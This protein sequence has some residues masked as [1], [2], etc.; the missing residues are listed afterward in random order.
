MVPPYWAIG[1]REIEARVTSGRRIL[2]ACDFDGTLAPIVAQP[3]AARLPTATRLILQRLM[4]CPGVSLAFVSGRQLADLRDRVRLDGAMY[5]GNH[6]LEI[7]G[8][9]FSHTHDGRHRADL[10][11]ALALLREAT[12]RMRGVR[13]EDK[14]LTATVRWRMAAAPEREALDRLV[15]EVVGAFATL[16]LTTGK[17]IWEI[18]PRTPMNKGAAVLELLARE[19]VTPDHAIFLGDDETDESAFEALCEGITIRVGDTGATAA[20]FRARDVK[21]TASFLFWLLVKR[22]RQEAAL[23]TTAR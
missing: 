21:D 9:K 1:G 19:A 7:E 5:C 11:A 13:I 20:H 6:G 23:D 8:P 2:L 17:A 22:S 12:A 14:G 18:R 4:A 3:E 10:E 16:H 15:P